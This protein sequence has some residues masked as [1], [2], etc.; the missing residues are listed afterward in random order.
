MSNAPA[1]NNVPPKKD[2]ASAMAAEQEGKQPQLVSPANETGGKATGSKKPSGKKKSRWWWRWS[3]RLTI[4]AVCARIVLWLFLE[5]LANFGAGFAGLSVSWRSA[6]LSITGLSLHIEDLLVRDANDESAP[7]L[8]AAQEV[9]ADLSMRQLL[10]GQL[11]VVDAGL[12]GA[13]VTLHRNADGTLR[14]PKA[15][16][17]PAAVTLP[18]PEAEPEDDAPLSFALPCW[19]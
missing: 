17:E 8:L 3:K 9:V 6:S 15:W 14:L 16:L 18:E 19:I 13:R 7:P 2:K 1:N 5:Q 12:A 4:A 10:G 11:S